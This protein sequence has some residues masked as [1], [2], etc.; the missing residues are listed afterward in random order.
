MTKPYTPI[1][2]GAPGEEISIR[3]LRTIKLRFKKLHQIRM[4]AIY[5]F[6]QP[7]Q[8]VFLDLLP[9]IFH[10][11]YPLL[12]AYVSHS[13]PAGIYGYNPNSRT[14]NSARK[15]LKTFHPGQTPSPWRAIDSLFL[16]GSA[17]SIAFAKTS[18]IDIWLCH[19]PDL[20]LSEIAELARKAQAV[21]EWANTL[22]LEVHIFLMNSKQFRLGSDVPISEESS[23]KTQHYLLLEEFYRTSIYIAGKYLAWWLVPPE[24]E[25]NYQHYLR[26]LISHRFIDESQFIDF[27]GLNAVPAEEFISAT[28][29]HIYK[30]LKSPF[31]SLLKLLLMECYACEY[32]NTRWLSQSIKQAIYQGNFTSV[33]LDPYVLIYLKV[34]NYLK[35]AQN[36]SR[37]ALARQNFY[38]KIMQFCDEGL[39]PQT[40]AYREQ[41][42]L[43]IAQRCHWP[44][45][46]VAELKQLRQ[47]DIKKAV[48]EHDTILQQLTHCFRII[49]GFATDHVSQTYRQS[50]DL[51][52]IGRK[53]YSF[54]DKRTGKVEVLT[55]RSAVK[56]REFE[57]AIAKSENAISPAWHLYLRKDLESNL[58]HQPILTCAS[59]IE[60]MAWLIVNGFY[61]PKLQLFFGLN[62]SILSEELVKILAQLDTF[63]NHHYQ[64]DRSLSHYRSIDAWLKSVIVVNM[65]ADE[66]QQSLCLIS[67]HTDIL[68]YGAEQQCLIQLCDRVSISSWS[69]ITSNHYEGTEGF[70]NCLLDI[71]NQHKKPTSVD[72]LTIVCQTPYRAQSIQQRVKEI[73]AALNKLLISSKP[74]YSPRHI[75]AAGNEFFLFYVEGKTLC[76]KLLKTVDQLLFE[77][78]RAQPCFSQVTFDP[79]TLI[80]TPL[81]LIFKEN[82]PHSIQCFIGEKNKAAIVYALDENGSLF[83]RQ[84]NEAAPRHL[85]AQYSI[86]LQSIGKRLS[87]HALNKLEWF[88]IL[89]NYAGSYQCRPLTLP[90][91]G[92]SSNFDLCIRES[93]Q[94]SNQG[95]VIQCNGR[96]FESP[97][98][99]PQIYH[100]VQQ[101]VLKLRASGSRYPIYITDVAL[102]ASA[103]GVN[104][105]NQLQTVHYLSMKRKIEEKF[106]S[107]PYMN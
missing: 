15:L 24:Q 104:G 88:E 1:Q 61:H 14:L 39:S 49:M 63:L 60:I 4:D 73:F 69:E 32:P 42:L 72:D 68:S 59:L 105:S 96:T 82:R 31:K 100:A 51:K 5:D 58:N 48:V 93:E 26:H 62:K 53:L 35:Q 37:L 52:L 66:T 99:N 75:V 29:W 43:D 28:L 106:N 50:D 97:Q 94:Q 10:G 65:A 107:L 77:L 102:P 80:K 12:P 27:G 89:E 16:M 21:E 81:P 90:N 44:V 86:F 17:G 23:G 36:E 98:L 71:A 30:S 20:S 19:R 64:R 95:Y 87:S 101:H 25:N 55:T 84:H 70:F 83:V 74:H 67:E 45:N 91:A 8:Q 56:N 103:F 18:D 85:F 40:L 47:W 3:D 22:D 13:A 2:L 38:L 7:R 92:P 79:A 9:L 34:E 46:T 54:L 76:V 6:L 78:A 41:Y 11:N 33:D 57:L